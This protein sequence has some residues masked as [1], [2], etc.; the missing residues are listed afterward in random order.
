M[1]RVAACPSIRATGAPHTGHSAG[2]SNRGASGARFSGST[3]RR[4]CGITSPARRTTTRSPTRTSLR[5][6]SSWLLQG[7]VGHRHPAHEHRLEASHRGQRAGPPH[8]HVDPEEGGDRLLG[9][10]L[11]G[12]RPAGRPRDRAELALLVEAV[13]LVHDPVDLVAER[14]PPGLDLPVVLD[15]SADPSNH[16]H[17]G[18]HPKAPLVHPPQEVAVG[19]GGRDAG[20]IARPVA[21]EHE[22]PGARRPRIRAGAARP[23]PRSAGSRTRARPARAAPRFRRSKRSRGR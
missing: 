22:A 4:T 3:A 12:E 11:V 19:R 5:A 10:E 2:I 18:G 1:H 6:I 20:R 16:P 15:A 21:E 23:P 9:G 13:D 7:R 8:L 14:L 17:V